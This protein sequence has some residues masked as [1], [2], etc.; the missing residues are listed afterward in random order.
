MS[1]PIKIFSRTY[2][3]I[4]DD[5]NTDT[6]TRDVPYWIK[7]IFAGIFYSL[8]VMVNIIANQLFT[9]TVE[10]RDIAEDI[11]AMTDYRLK[12][13]TTASADILITIDPLA[14][15][16][17]TYTI[18]LSDLKALNVPT[19]ENV[20]P[21][22]WEART[23]ITFAIGQTTASHPFYQQV[24]QSSTI[25]GT[26]DGSN[27]RRVYLTDKYILEDTITITIGIDTY[28]PVETFAY[29]IATD[30]HFIFK[31][32]E[33]GTSY[34]EFGF[35]DEI[36]GNQ[37]GLIPLAGQTIN[38]TYA[39]GGGL[40]TNVDA[41]TITQYIGLDANVVSINNVYAA[42][43][44]SDGE[45]IEN[46]K[47]IAP[48]RAR[49]HDQ[50]WNVESGVVI[51]LQASGVI[52]IDVLFTDV[53][54]CDVFVT[55]YGGGFASAG[56]KTDVYNRL[57]KASPFEQMTITIKD[58]N[59]QTWT[60]NISVELFTGY[61]LQNTPTQVN[62]IMRKIKL[63][64]A[65]R[66]YELGYFIFDYYSENGVLATVTNIINVDLFGVTGFTYDP[67]KESYIEDYLKF[68]KAEQVKYPN[69]KFSK[70]KI[71][72]DDIIYILRKIEGIKR[73]V[74]INPS[75]VYEVSTDTILRPTSITVNQI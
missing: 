3:E 23:P 42:S 65:L 71:T 39:I 75:G 43:G 57:L 34:I 74:P 44:G 6:L 63:M 67:T 16:T 11:F 66:T 33:D 32:L 60:P 8:S 49:T 19:N 35:V 27:S 24:S 58:P 73:V 40:T 9:R 61:I 5:L 64:V 41:N 26:T 21:F 55:P 20:S 62:D 18:G 54:A 72:N 13:R 25:I 17:T 31:N 47:R 50:F 51:G 28:T 56:V 45:T 36:S 48:L 30:K 14:T 69:G 1:N 59:Y 46:A 12:N 70:N 22:N 2:S 4:I 37:Y 53:F 68:L 10:A 38:A 52:G 15:A 7:A 29:S